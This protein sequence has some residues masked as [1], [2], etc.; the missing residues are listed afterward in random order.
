ME[1]RPWVAVDPKDPDASRRI[2]WDLSEDVTGSNSALVSATITEV[3]C[4]DDPLD[5]PTV[6][7]G[8]PEVNPGGYVTAL[9]SG[10]TVGTNVYLK[11]SYALANT[12]SDD[13]TLLIPIRNR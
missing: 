1:T 3:D 7:V 10:G 8:T 6:T 4:C 13:A 11:C 12:E 2:Q 9:V 5:T